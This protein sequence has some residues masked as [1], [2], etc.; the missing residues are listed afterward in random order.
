MP[1]HGQVP[2]LGSVP[3]VRVGLV[4]H[5]LLRCFGRRTAGRLGLVARARFG[6]RASGTAELLAQQQYPSL[7]VSLQTKQP[8]DSAGCQAAYVS[9]LAK[10]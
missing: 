1:G 9:G 3:L 2:V 10:V 5:A 4:V 8:Q 6:W 7:G